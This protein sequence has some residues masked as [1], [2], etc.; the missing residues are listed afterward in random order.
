[1][2]SRGENSGGGGRGGESSGTC[3]SSLSVNKSGGGGNSNRLFPLSFSTTGVFNSSSRSDSWGTAS[4]GSISFCESVLVDSITLGVS[5]SEMS[6]SLESVREEVLTGFDESLRFDSIVNLIWK[7]FLVVIVLVTF[8]GSEVFAGIL[9]SDWELLS[10]HGFNKFSESL[11]CSAGHT[12][13]GTNTS[14]LESLPVPL[15]QEFKLQFSLSASFL[16][17]SSKNI[18]DLSSSDK[19]GAGISNGRE[20]SSPILGE[21]L[22]VFK[23]VLPSLNSPSYFRCLKSNELNRF[24][25]ATGGEGLPRELTALI[26]T[27]DFILLLFSS[28]R[29]GPLWTAT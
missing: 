26:S 17:T 2:D 10:Y 19:T 8:S 15:F 12:G 25:G 11:F 7:P 6:I 23:V 3:G 16:I 21:W 1:M 4:F 18:T 22:P 24:L 9:S 14:L 28:L 20:R 27:W 13:G 5:G 29:S